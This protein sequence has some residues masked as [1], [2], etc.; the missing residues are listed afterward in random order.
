MVGDVVRGV[1]TYIWS[2][3]VLS[4]ST[5]VTGDSRGHVQL[6]DGEVGVLM[7][8]LHQHTAEIMALAVSPDESQIFASGVDCRV[9]CVRKVG[10]KFGTSPDDLPLPS[11]NNWVYSTS[12]NPHSH[13]VFALEVC[14][15]TPS[16][17]SGVGGAVLISGGMDTKLCSY[18][19][20]E[21]ARTRPFCILPVLAKGLIQSSTEY[22]TVA[23]RHQTRIDIWSVSP[24]P[25]QSIGHKRKMKSEDDE[26]RCKL[27]LRLEVKGDEHL[28]C[29]ALSADGSALCCSTTT[30]TRIWSLKTDSEGISVDK[31]VLP[32]IAR[33]FC[34]AMAFSADGR[35]IAAY[36]AKG[37]LVLLSL[38]EGPVEGESDEES[39]A[40][41]EEENED[42]EDEAEVKPKRKSSKKADSA[43]KTVEMETK[44]KLWHS[45]DHLEIVKDMRTT[46]GNSLSAL[47]GLEDV[48][49]QI[50]FSPDGA[51]LAVADAQNT[52]YVYDIDR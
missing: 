14:N 30:E 12:H 13:D 25:F 47:P 19:V 5:I 15:S 41:S 21:F 42:S 28:H 8:T 1:S 48:V 49:T 43:P 10:P 51:Y 20:D 37:D 2:I 3:K 4:D 44:V 50:V 36:T 40:E 9:T 24:S 34:H 29:F 18:S 33:G 31:L 46:G 39:E 22:D 27:S 26:S 35:R 17:S 38:V 32:A 6:W 11:D 45:F 7:I 16:S 52:V 23:V